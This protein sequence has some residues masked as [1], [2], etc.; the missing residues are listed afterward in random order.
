MIKEAED[1][2]VTRAGPD[3]VISDADLLLPPSVSSEPDVGGLVAP[4]SE[5]GESSGFRHSVMLVVVVCACIGF[6]AVNLFRREGYT[7]DEGF[8]G[9][10]ALN[11]LHAPSYVL[12]PSYYPLGDFAADKDGF[13]HLPFNS[14]F[15]ALSLAV[16]RGS[17]AG[18][19]VVNAISLVLLLFFSYRIL[20]LFDTNA[21]LFAVLLLGASPAT[22]LYYSQLEAEP[23]MTTAGIAALYYALRAGPGLDRKRCL[24]F[25]GICLGL[26]FAFKLWLFGPLALATGVALI[27][28]TGT[29]SH[30]LKARAFP[31][32]STGEASGSA[33][34]PL[35]LGVIVFAAGVIIPAGLHLLA[36][37]CFYP[38]DLGYW[39]KNIY[40]GVFTNA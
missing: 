20:R 38:A 12:R 40:F 22:F 2:R 39:I 3:S 28:R 30:F 21:A 26:A 18:P 35:L 5:V 31:R 23:L 6:L 11:M 27:V 19:E 25:S 29:L 33:L 14:Y 8:Y 15:Y 24:F 37:A 17:L 10:T 9:V 1:G 7:G 16:S 34:R 13:A 4:K 36:V 32:G